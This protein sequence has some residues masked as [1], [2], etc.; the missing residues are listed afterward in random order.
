[1]SKP[2]EVEVKPTAPT[3]C[4]LVHAINPSIRHPL[5]LEVEAVDGRIQ[6][7]HKY[8]VKDGEPSLTGARAGLTKAGAQQLAIA[9][10]A[11]IQQLPDEEPSQRQPILRLRPDP[12]AW[13]VPA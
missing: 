1:M 11:V 8:L 13:D 9:L 4:F 7:R 3:S 2:T 10:L 6:L 5:L 12:E